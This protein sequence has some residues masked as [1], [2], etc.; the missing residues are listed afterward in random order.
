MLNPQITRIVFDYTR[1]WSK[2]SGRKVVAKVFS[3]AQDSAP[4]A[5]Q[6]MSGVTPAGAMQ[7]MPT[8]AVKHRSAMTQSAESQQAFPVPHHYSTNYYPAAAQM[9]PKTATDSTHVDASMATAKPVTVEP[10][11]YIPTT[12]K[13]AAV[14]VQETSVKDSSSQPANNWLSLPSQKKS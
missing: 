14:K 11:Q 5:V 7:E 6:S 9:S 12:T 1:P 10:K 3:P 8:V 2:K 4:T 13:P